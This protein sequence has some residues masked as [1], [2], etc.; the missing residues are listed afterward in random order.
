MIEH[1]AYVCIRPLLILNFADSALHV[2]P[3]CIVLDRS[4]AGYFLKIIIKSQ[5]GNICDSG[6]IL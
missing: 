5:Y 4:K 2:I 6:K 1:F 3:A